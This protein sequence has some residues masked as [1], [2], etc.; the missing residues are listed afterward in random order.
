MVDNGPGVTSEDRAIAFKR[1]ARGGMQT[2]TEGF[3]IGLALANWIIKQQG[4]RI[5]MTSPVPD[6]LRLGTQPGT[7][8]T[9]FLPP[10][11]I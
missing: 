11:S 1:F 10:L 9:V 6:P 4:G 3:G 8:V 5:E 2:K 7:L